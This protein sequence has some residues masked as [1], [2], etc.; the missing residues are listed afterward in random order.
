MRWMSFRPLYLL[1]SAIALGFS[2]Y[3]IA[4]FGFA[5]SID[6][7]GGSVTEYQF[8]KEVQVDDV[9]ITLQSQ[10]L[11]KW[12]AKDGQQL[13]SNKV[14]L[15]FVPEF[16][17]TDAQSLPA[18][19]D[20]ELGGKPQLLRLER[21]GP[22]LSREI[23]EKTYVAIAIAAVGI[24]LW[25]A[26]QFKSLMF[27]I[28][29]IL[30]MIHDSVILLGTFAWLGHLKG[31]E[32][33]ILFVTAM[34]T[35]LSFSVH[36]TIVVYDRIREI[37][38]K[39]YGVAMFDLANKALTET[40]VRSVNNSLTIIFM[41]SALFLMGG[42]SIKWFVFALLVGTVRELILPHLLQFRFW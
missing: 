26:Y 18:I 38:R 24:L 40:M 2:L 4:V 29:A 3:G 19:L 16:D 12:R 34:L 35:V 13:S 17:Q 36:D 21:V 9:V 31:V 15:K 23:L 14:Q 20:G 7:T 32:V 10:G 22:S 6:F 28:S 33:D 41:L 37:S 30:A 5:Y 1:V 11:E 42:D 8:N 39:N 25:V 27:G